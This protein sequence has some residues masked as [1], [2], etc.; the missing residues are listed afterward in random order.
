MKKYL[1][2]MLFICIAAFLFSSSAFAAL[3]SGTWDQTTTDKI[4]LGTWYE[5]A[6]G[7]TPDWVGSLGFED[8]SGGQWTSRTVRGNSSYSAPAWDG[9]YFEMNFVTTYDQWAYHCTFFDE[10]PYV[11]YLSGD[12]TYKLYLTYNPISGKFVY[13]HAGPITFQ[14]GANMVYEDVANPLLHPTNF[15]VSYTATGVTNHYTPENPDD[16]WGGAITYAT[17]TLTPNSPPVPIPG[18]VWLFGSGLLGLLG[19]RR[20]VR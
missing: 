14:G 20:R 13:N 18:A 9:T 10:N 1:A 8:S 11:A 4:E 5:Q 17:L 16:S 15:S 6:Q 7:A 12:A 19:I 3:W 2:T